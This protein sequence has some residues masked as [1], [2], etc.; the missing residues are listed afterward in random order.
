MLMSTFNKLIFIPTLR[1]LTAKLYYLYP[2]KREIFS[3]SSSFISPHM[4]EDEEDFFR[5]ASLKWAKF[6]AMTTLFCS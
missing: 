2:K 1:K 5:A 3:S 4:H 6:Y